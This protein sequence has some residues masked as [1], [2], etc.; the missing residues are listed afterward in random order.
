[1]CECAGRLGEE[2]HSIFAAPKAIVR[3]GKLVLLALRSIVC[4][5]EFAGIICSFG[6]AHFRKNYKEKCEFC[7][8]LKISS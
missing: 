3:C 1:M 8:L 6:R 5:T 7:C 2:Q 4:R